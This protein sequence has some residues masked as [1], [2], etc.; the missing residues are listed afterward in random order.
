MLF[1]SIAILEVLMELF[2]RSPILMCY[3]YVSG[4]QNLFSEVDAQLHMHRC[5]PPLELSDFMIVTHVHHV[6]R[7]KCDTIIVC[8]YVTYT[9]G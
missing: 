3:H 1:T 5:G 8:K 7:V 6:V 2:I 9:T 4:M